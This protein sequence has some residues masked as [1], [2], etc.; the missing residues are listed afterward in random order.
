MR[1]AA[2]TLLLLL[3]TLAVV[4]SRQRSSRQGG[5]GDVGDDNDND[6]GEE[7]NIKMLRMSVPG[8]PGVDYPILATVPSTSFSCVGKAE[9]GYYAD[10]ETGCQVVHTCGGG[11]KVVNKYSFI[12]YSALCSNGTIYSQEIGTCH[13][14]YLVDCESSE[15]YYF[16]Q[17][18]IRVDS[19]QSS[20]QQS[21]GGVQSTSSSSSSSSSVQGQSGSGSGGGSQNQVQNQN[22]QASQGQGGGSGS[23]S[24]NQQ[25]SVGGSSSSN[26]QSSV[27]GQSFSLVPV[28]ALPPIRFP[29][30]AGNE[31]N[32][33]VIN[34]ATTEIAFYS[35]DDFNFDYLTDYLDETQQLTTSSTS[36]PRR[37]TPGFFELRA[38]PKQLSYHHGKIIVE[39]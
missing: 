16:S 22:G 19:S 38:P 33:N 13:W 5:G 9:G 20:S 6:N 25:S 10:V 27:G 11:S 8:E 39:D 4:S 37:P 7:M 12:K 1:D 15:K 23:S 14:W 26:S 30:G 17:N 31:I 29:G 18:N 3:P 2:T 32:S 24:S 34:S 35:A 36:R 21:T 28:G